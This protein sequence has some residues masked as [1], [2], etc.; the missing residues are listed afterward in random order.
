VGGEGGRDV[1]C[2]TGHTGLCVITVVE[3]ARGREG[4][5]ERRG[6][7][8]GRKEGRRRRE[9]RSAQSLFTWKARNQAEL[10]VVLCFFAASGYEWTRRSIGEAV[11][12]HFIIWLALRSATLAVALFHHLLLDFAYFIYTPS[13][14]LIGVFSI[15]SITTI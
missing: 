6:R 9:R 1:R 10:R 2:W 3:V 12:N 7:K 13:F 15:Y 8:E 14:T 5:E 4:R 11:L